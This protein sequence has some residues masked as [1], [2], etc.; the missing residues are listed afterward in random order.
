MEQEIRDRM[1][2]KMVSVNPKLKLYS[3]ADVVKPG[4]ILCAPLEG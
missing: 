2:S 3:R 1:H 4:W